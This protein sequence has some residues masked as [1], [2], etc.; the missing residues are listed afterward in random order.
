MIETILIVVL[1]GAGAICINAVI[2]CALFK[3]W[4]LYES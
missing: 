3:W 2:M 4:S 1:M